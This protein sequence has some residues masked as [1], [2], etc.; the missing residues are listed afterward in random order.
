M[1]LSY[2]IWL[3]SLRNFLPFFFLPNFPACLFILIYLKGKVTKSKGNQEEVRST[4]NLLVHSP[5]EHNDQARPKPGAWH[6]STLSSKLD[7]TSSWGWNWCS[8]IGCVLSEQWLNLLC[9]NTHPSL[10]LVI[11]SYVDME[12]Q[13]TKHHMENIASNFA[14][15]VG[16]TGIALMHLESPTHEGSTARRPIC[17]LT[18]GHERKQKEF[19]P[20]IILPGTSG[21][22][23][24]LYGS[25]IELIKP[26][27][28][29]RFGEHVLIS[30]K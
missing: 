29:L 23:L 28:T 21:F 14:F 9:H 18:F 26:T 25:R 19:C 20:C 16:K 24:I 1:L 30:L 13:A 15:C 6:L 11:L 10:C 3:E 27:V 7:Y 5:E 8:N 22:H 2:T 17:S 12:H 4:L